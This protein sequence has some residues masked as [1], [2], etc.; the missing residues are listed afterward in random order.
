MALIQRQVSTTW[1]FES[2]VS[3]PVIDRGSAVFQR[4]SGLGCFSSKVYVGKLHPWKWMAATLNI[5]PIKQQINHQRPPFWGVQKPLIFQGENILW[6]PRIAKF[7]C[8][9]GGTICCVVCTSSLQFL[10]FSKY[11]GAKGQGFLA[12]RCDDELNYHRRLGVRIASE[13]MT[14]LWRFAPKKSKFK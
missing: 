11:F 13:M 14:S 3:L 2:E 5:I 12:L 6:S 1:I 8:F 10:W 7:V 4:F 9:A